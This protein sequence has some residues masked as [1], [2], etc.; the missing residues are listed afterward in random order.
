MFKAG[1][2]AII[3]T[4]VFQTG[5]LAQLYV[6]APG[7]VGIG[8]ATPDFKLQ[9]NGFTE[10]GDQ[11]AHD[12][13][14]YGVLQL[15]RPAN[16]GDDKFHLSFIRAANSVSG[17]GY[18]PNTNSFALW[19]CTN[20]NTSTPTMAFPPDGNVGIGIANPTAKLTIPD[21]GAASLRVGV[22]SNMANTYTQLLNSMAVL[23]D[24]PTTMSSCG[25]VA[26]D[27]F[28]NGNSPSWSG[29]MLQ[30][31]GRN[32]SGYQYGIAAANQ[33][34]LLFQNVGA[35]VIATNGANIHISPVGNV[36]ATFL[37]NGNVGIGTQSPSYKLHVMGGVWANNYV[38]AS[39]NNYADYVFD[40]TYQ[41]PSLQ[42]VSAYINQNH[43]LPDVPS[44]EEVKKDGIN[45]V[46]HQVI[47]LK[48]IEELT[49]YV[50]EQNKQN[51][52]LL[53]IEKKLTELTAENAE[54]KAAI[55]DL[56]AKKNKARQ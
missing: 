49:L 19:A 12:S 48:K 22:N 50:I 18:V 38:A 24:A 5:A 3:G 31:F 37:T 16:Q 47:L 36:T 13:Y 46:D 21:A 30:H 2:T 8:I 6:K 39:P 43:H 1:L 40:S 4:L 29:A 10:I 41:L 14:K 20:A 7:N 42:E 51:E 53:L 52:K 9:V 25:A 35:G 17:F 54:L 26:C 44:E 11:N 45:L 15:I 33:G 34:T 55:K 23:A 32:I 56:Q 28:N 27:F